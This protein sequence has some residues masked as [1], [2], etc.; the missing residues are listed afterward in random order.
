MSSM[1]DERYAEAGF[2]Y[3]TEANDFLVEVAGAIPPGPVVCLAEGEG[4]N[5]VFLAARGHQVLAIDQSVVGLEKARRLAAERGVSIETQAMDLADFQVEANSYAGIVSIWAHM[6]PNVRKVVHERCVRALG[7]G[8]VMILEAYT[9]A[10]VGRGTGGP[11]DPAF[12]MSADRL[13]E[14][15]RGLDFD[16]LLERE[17]HVAEG[18]YHHGS[19]LVV[20]MLA[21]KPL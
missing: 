12:C 4:R 19:S 10:Q 7:P 13:R 5:A 11:P 17:R 20:Q 21:R 15:L 3:G 1:W 16:V 9:P 6:P 14:E 2:A 18:K 8:G